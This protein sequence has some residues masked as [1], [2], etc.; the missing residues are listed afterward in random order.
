MCVCPHGASIHVSNLKNQLTVS[1]NKAAVSET[2]MRLKDAA[3]SVILLERN[4]RPLIWN[5]ERRKKMTMTSLIKMRMEVLRRSREEG[6][7][8]FAAAPNRKCQSGD[9]LVQQDVRRCVQMV[10]QRLGSLLMSTANYHMTVL[11]V[12]SQRTPG[13]PGK[14]SV[15]VMGLEQANAK[16][17]LL[18]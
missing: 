15:S 3:F 16:L 9:V 7:F 1:C 12:Q 4:N 17:T 6:C 14:P 18:C 10:G 2:L 5:K 11:C 8:P 13:L